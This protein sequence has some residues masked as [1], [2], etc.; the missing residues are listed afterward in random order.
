VADQK[1]LTLGQLREL[2]T[3]EELTL[4][5]VYYEVKA[6]HEARKLKT[7]AGRR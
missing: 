4:W 3:P 5:H 1:G 2:I 7:T 6:E